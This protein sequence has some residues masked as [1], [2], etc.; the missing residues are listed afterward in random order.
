[1]P[2]PG[3][4]ASLQVILNVF[5]PKYAETL[6]PECLRR[7]VAVLARLPLTSGLLSGKFGEDA[8]FE[9]SDHRHYNRDGQAFSVGETFAGISFGKGVQLARRY[10]EFLPAGWDPAQVAL[11]FCLDHEAVTAV[12]PGASR[13]GQVRRNAEVSDLPSLPET[14]VQALW[15]FQEEEVAPFLRRRC[16][17]EDS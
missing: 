13:A 4:L 3:G 9:P 16:G 8:R 11:R 7:G 15:K 12:I 6:F 2:G 10:R 1:M 5:R 14:V 17:A